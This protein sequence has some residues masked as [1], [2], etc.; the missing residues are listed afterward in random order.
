MPTCTFSWLPAHGITCLPIIGPAGKNLGC[1]R[2]GDGGAK[3]FMKGFWNMP[4]PGLPVKPLAGAA[5][6]IRGPNGPGT[7]C[8]IMKGDWLPNGLNDIIE[9]W[10]NGLCPNGCCCPNWPD[11]LPP[12]IGLVATNLSSG[13][14]TK[15]DSNQFHQIQRLARIVKFRL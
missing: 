6:N 14:P 1:P 12:N 13:F 2:K 5:P 3:A 15:L 9:L 8:G 10:P 4:N 11:E 7:I